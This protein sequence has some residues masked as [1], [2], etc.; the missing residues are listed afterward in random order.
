MT[1]VAV[2]VVVIM[3]V[4]AGNSSADS[5]VTFSADGKKI[6]FDDVP[7]MDL[8]NKALDFDR[9]PDQYKPWIGKV[10]RTDME[11]HSGRKGSRHYIFLTRGDEKNIEF[12][13]SFTSGRG[14]AKVEV[15][16]C[17]VVEGQAGMRCVRPGMGYKLTSYGG[18]PHLA[19]DDGWAG[20][21]EEVATMPLQTKN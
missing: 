16:T 5:K 19:A 2:L 1:R 9:I 6:I 4:L 11:L 13:D 18:K 8:S 20:T 12:I 10:Y 3:I 14:G 21:F 7:D 15:L 17:R